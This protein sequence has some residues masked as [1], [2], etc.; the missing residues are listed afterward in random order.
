[1]AGWLRTVVVSANGFLS[2]GNKCTA[3][4]TTT[5]TITATT[6]ATILPSHLV[7]G[8]RGIVILSSRGSRFSRVVPENCSITPFRHVVGRCLFPDQGTTPDRADN[9][10]QAAYRAVPGHT[11]R[12]EVQIETARRLPGLVQGPTSAVAATIQGRR[13]PDVGGAADP[14]PYRD[15]FA[16]RRFPERH[17]VWQPLP[18]PR[19]PGCLQGRRLAGTVSDRCWQG[20]CVRGGAEAAGPVGQRPGRLM[21][22]P[23]RKSTR[24]NSSHLGIS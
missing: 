17:Q 18:S 9:S 8:T 5:R 12:H 19:R 16:V 24:L 6:V 14:D 22:S 15:R 1:M 11:Y 21:V 23:D 10:G 4:N 7:P 20:C 13:L 3:D 2:C